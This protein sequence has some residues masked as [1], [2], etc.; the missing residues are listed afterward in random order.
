MALKYV[1]DSLPWLVPSAAIAFAAFVFMD[2]DIRPGGNATA[3][4]TTAPAVAPEIVPQPDEIVARQATADTDLSSVAPTTALAQPVAAPLPTPVPEPKP[5]P[6][7]QAALATAPTTTPVFDNSGFKAG[8]NAQCIEDLKSMA[9]EARVYFPSGGLTADAAGIEQGKLLGLIAANC[10]NVQIRVDG[11]S[12]PSGD[13][14]ANLLLSERRAQ[15]VI[16]RIGASGLDTSMFFARGVGDR[17]PSGIVGPQSSA[18]YDRRVE[19]SIVEETTRVAVRTTVSPSPW[20]DASCV[21]DLE[22]AVESTV[23]FYSPRSVS[24][25]PDD[26]DAAM[27]LAQMAVE[28]PH[29]RLRVIGQHAGG[30]QTGE[31]VS[32]G[33]LR[34]KALMAMLV[35][36]GIASEQIIIAAPSRPMGVADQAGLPGSRVDF[37][38]IL[39]E[40]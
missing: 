10:P 34:A 40:G 1:K 14:T 30:V 29:A 16:K 9:S 32:T 5:E 2:G 12:D 17:Q 13:P 4:D 20:A 3:A 33:R 25:R 15:E 31:D 18:Y 38:V 7:R 22:R 11:H 24:L 19:F 27:R 36:R 23:L 6:V 37:D 39:E 8:A 28:C 35:G 21:T 26:L